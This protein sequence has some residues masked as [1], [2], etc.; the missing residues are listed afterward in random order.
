M[1][2]DLKRRLRDEVDA[3]LG[4]RPPRD[5]ADVLNRGRG[6][7]LVRRLMT[8]MSIVLVGTALVAGGLWVDQTNSSGDDASPVPP[9]DSRPSPTGSAMT[10]VE[11]SGEVDRRAVMSHCEFLFVEGCKD[12]LPGIDLVTVE[13]SAMKVGT[14]VSGSGSIQGEGLDE[15]FTVRCSTEVLDMIAVGGSFDEGGRAGDGILLIIKDGIQ[16]DSLA[17]FYAKYKG[18]ASEDGCNSLLINGEDRLGTEPGDLIPRPLRS[19]NFTI[20]ND[21]P[22]PPQATGER[23]SLLGGDVTFS[24]VSPWGE[25]VEWNMIAESG[26]PESL[27]LLDDDATG[28]NAQLLVIADPVPAK[29]VEGQDSDCPGGRADVRSAEAFASAVQAHPGL[30]STDP[31]IQRIAGVDAFR[32]DVAPAQG[33]QHCH[34]TS[35]LW[36]GPRGHAGVPVVMPTRDTYFGPP[37]EPFVVPDGTRMRVYLL[38][39]P[40]GDVRTLAVAILAPRDE[41]NSAVGAAK[42]ILDSLELQGSP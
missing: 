8:T 27:L 34:G 11:G 9:A 20:G 39:I 3:D 35:T 10:I 15:S 21:A 22:E 38:D 28:S 6:K 24:E 32:L 23:I 1:H 12:V 37:T 2:D 14:D 25:H 29:P 13:V 41:F 19:G 42:P 36:T 4:S 33:S 30:S 5:L 18:H 7:R 26:G 17:I 16:R 40:R 31:V